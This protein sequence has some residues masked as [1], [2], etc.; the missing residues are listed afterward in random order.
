MIKNNE[1][2]R[3]LGKLKPIQVRQVLCNSDV[4][5]L[6]SK[7]EGWGCVVNEALMSGCRVIT[8]SVVGARALIGKQKER[9]QIFE[10]LNW[11]DLKKCV[12]R[13]LNTTREGKI[14]IL[15]WAQNITPKREAE[16]FLEI[17]DYLQGKTKQ[18]PHSPWN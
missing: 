2:I 9:G 8:S 1:R 15:N 5:V 16:Y 4:L 14:D 17:L 6:P 13:E 18:R 11:S 7:L 3:Y 12:L 10:N